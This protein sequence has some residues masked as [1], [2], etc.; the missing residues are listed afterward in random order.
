[1]TTRM[2]VGWRWRDAADMAESLVGTQNLG[3]SMSQSV[4]YSVQSNAL[5]YDTVYEISVLQPM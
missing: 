2:E 3:P 5:Y 4:N 1:M